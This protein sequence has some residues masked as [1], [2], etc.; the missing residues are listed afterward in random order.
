VAKRKK[1]TEATPPPEAT[2][3][4]GPAGDCAHKRAYIAQV[5]T[6]SQLA[7]VCPDC[8]ERKEVKKDAVLGERPMPFGQVDRMTAQLDK[9]NSRAQKV[10]REIKAAGPESD[11]GKSLR[12]QLD[13]LDWE[14]RH[15]KRRL[16]NAE[17]RA[18]R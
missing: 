10:A 7:Q 12:V 16:A 8:G 18:A 9:L 13:N 4:A 14:A 17:A 6:K 15:A 3:V 2:P 1:E 11:Q 5:G